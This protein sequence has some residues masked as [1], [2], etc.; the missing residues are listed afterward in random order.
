MRV[1]NNTLIIRDDDIDVITASLELMIRSYE[2]LV[3]KGV[4]IDEETKETI[5]K[6]KRLHQKMIEEFY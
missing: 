4:H 5:V 3:L 1:G 6:A 2:K